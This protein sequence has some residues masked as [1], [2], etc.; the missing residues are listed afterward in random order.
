[1]VGVGTGVRAAA[2]VGEGVTGAAGVGEGVTG[3]AGVGEGEGAGAGAARDTYART[4][5]RKSGQARIVGGDVCVSQLLQEHP[6]PD[7]AG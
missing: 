6:V 4:T 7:T 3:A 2:G 5:L 1:M